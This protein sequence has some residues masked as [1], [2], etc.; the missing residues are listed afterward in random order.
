MEN[1]ISKYTKN[2]GKVDYAATKKL[3]EE[4]NLLAEAKKQSILNYECEISV[5][6]KTYYVSQNGDDNND[7]LSPKTAWKTIQKVNDSPIADGDAVLFER[8]GIYRGMILCD[9]NVTYSAYGKGPK[10]V[11]TC[12]PENGAGKEKWRLLPG[13]DNIWV[14]YKE[15]PETGLII[16]DDG[17]DYSIKKA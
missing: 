16:F 2:E 13:T 5:R 12:S 6:G 14:Y 8:G 1:L 17:K 3:I 10:P 9:S 7:G 4:I 11:I 15:L